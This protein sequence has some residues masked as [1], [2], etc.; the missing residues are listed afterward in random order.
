MIDPRDFHIGTVYRDPDNG[1]LLRVTGGCY[2]DPV[3]G[4]LSN[5]FYYVNVITG[6]KSSGYG[7]PMQEIETVSQT[8]LVDGDIVEVTL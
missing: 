1:D 7:R 3:Y 2:L 6:K 5:F 4:R 8:L